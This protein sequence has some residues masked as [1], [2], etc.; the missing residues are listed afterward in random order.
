[1]EHSEIKNQ[2]FSAFP[3]T[4]IASIIR[5]GNF[6]GKDV[7][8]FLIIKT[9]CLYN[10]WQRE[11]LD[12]TC[13]GGSNFFEMMRNLDPIVIDPILSGLEVFGNNLN[14]L[15]NIILKTKATKDTSMYLS[16][17]S[18]LFFEWAIQH[19]NQRNLVQASDA[20]R[21][22][23]SYLIFAKHYYFNEKPIKYLELVEYYPNRLLKEATALS[24]ADGDIDINKLEG[25]FLEVSKLINKLEN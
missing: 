8:V 19:L 18:S 22:S 1:M 3:Q 24:K 4:E 20:L 14:S 10:C 6:Y 15:K 25:L 7:D 17:V 16:K 2:I 12:V 23:I 21:F 11:L 5:Y 13:V 9:N